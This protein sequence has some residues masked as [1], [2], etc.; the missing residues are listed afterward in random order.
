MVRVHLSPP[1][2]R[3][4]AKNGSTTC[5][6]LAEQM[7]NNHLSPPKSRKWFGRKMGRPL[8]RRKPSKWQITIWAHQ[9]H[10]SDLGENGSAT[11][12]ALAEQMT[13]NHLS[14]PK[15]FC[16]AQMLPIIRF[17]RPALAR[18]NEDWQLHR[19]KKQVQKAIYRLILVNTSRK[20]RTILFGF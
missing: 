15:S 19:E 13:N 10:A 12:E 3:V 20:K 2:V 18:A 11:C 8:A 16:V 14:P 17:K 1:P 4:R 6:A 5:E 9:N 7:T